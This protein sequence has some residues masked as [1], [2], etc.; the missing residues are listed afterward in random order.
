MKSTLL[1]LLLT[2]LAGAAKSQDTIYLKHKRAIANADRK[3]IYTDRPPQA[4]FME[5]YGRGIVYSVN[6]DCR[7]QKKLK[8]MGFSAGVGGLVIAGIS[9]VA[10]PLTI[11]DLIGDN[12]HYFELGGG[13]T[14]TSGNFVDFNHIRTGGSS[15]LGTVTLGYRR[16]PVAGGLNF[17]GGI[18]IVGGNGMLAPYP[19]VSLGY[20]F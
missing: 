7:F 17:R 14:F 20:N 13:V 19:Y 18:N 15:M 3:I 12:G 16:Q 5:L 11:N 4:L 9:F 1:L 10:V 6:Y 8:G 2:L